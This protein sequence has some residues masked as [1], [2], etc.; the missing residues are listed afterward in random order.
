MADQRLGQLFPGGQPAPGQYV[1]RLHADGQPVGT[2][3][4]GIGPAGNADRW[5]VWAVEVDQAARGQGI[6]RRAMQLAEKEA[7][8]H[9]ATELGL[10]VF[11][12]NTVARS[13]YESLGYQI[14][15]INMR[16]QL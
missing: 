15:A 3:W 8:A 14:T 16:M 9:G 7:R 2:L 13:L 6:G 11:G 1:F 12:Q 5:W 10:N 4:I